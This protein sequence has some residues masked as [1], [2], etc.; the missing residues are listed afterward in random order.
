MRDTALDGLAETSRI[1]CR[2]TVIENDVFH[3]S[4]NSALSGAEITKLQEQLRKYLIEL[5]SK[6][7]KIQIQLVLRFERAP[8]TQYLRDTI[9]ADDWESMISDIKDLEE[10]NIQDINVSDLPHPTLV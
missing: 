6:I 2:Y 4:K 3:G 8:L 1:L 9:R 7:I 5:Y 10:S